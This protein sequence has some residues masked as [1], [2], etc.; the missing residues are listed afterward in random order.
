MDGITLWAR[1]DAAI[2]AALETEAGANSALGDL[3]LQK[4]EIAETWNLDTWPLPCAIVRST[5]AQQ[6]PAG[7]GGAVTHLTQIY[8]Y[9][10]LAAA[11]MDTDAN[12]R[13]AA[14]T[15]HKAI[16]ETIRKWPAILAAADDPT[17]AEKPVKLNWQRSEIQMIGN[18]G[19]NRG[20]KFGVVGVSFSIESI[21]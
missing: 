5:A 20:R 2:A 3:R 8:G 10:I 16:T 11:V 15:L 4:I 18:Q 19:T 21:I 1:L 6:R 14:Q 13:A 12:T 17:D 9:G 7:H